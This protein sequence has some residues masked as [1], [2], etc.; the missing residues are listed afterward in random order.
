MLKRFRILGRARGADSADRTGRARSAREAFA[1]RLRQECLENIAEQY[2]AAYLKHD[3]KL[4]AVREE[5]ALRRE[6]RGDGV[7]RR[8]AGIR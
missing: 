5:S 7:P 8:D 1:V 2:R 3:P 6:Q 4:S